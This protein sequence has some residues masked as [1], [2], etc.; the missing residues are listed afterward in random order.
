MGWLG[1]IVVV[2]LNILG[3]D[4]QLESIEH[5]YVR[6]LKFLNI[7]NQSLISLVGRGLDRQDRD[8][9]NV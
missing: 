9:I 4:D 7:Y 5:D 2:P 1:G 6:S 8:C 3:L